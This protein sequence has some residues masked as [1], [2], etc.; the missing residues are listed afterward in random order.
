[1]S[2]KN[3]NKIETNKYELEVTVEADKFKAAVD[4]AFKKNAVK[5]SVPGFR[6]GKAPRAIIE[7]MYGESVFYEDAV[8]MLYPEEYEA[9]VKEAKIEPVDRADVEIESVD[10][11]GFTFKAKV[12]VKPEVE[13]EEYKKLNAA[14]TV[15]KATAEDVDNEI[16]RIQ[17]RNAR[18]ITV[19]DRAAE[20]GDITV[21]DFDGYIDGKAFDGGKAE[22]YNLELGS[23]HFIP[24]FEDQIVGHNPGDSFDVNVKFPDDYQEKG[25]AGKETVFKVKLHEIKKK[26]LTPIDDEF[27]KDVSEFDTLDAMKADIEKHIQEAKDKQAEDDVENQLMSKL[28]EGMKAEIPEVMIEHAIDNQIGDFERRLQMQGISLDQYLAYAGLDMDKFRATFHDQAE[29]QVKVR[30]AL[31]KVVALENIEASDEEV[32]KEYKKIADNYG[33]DVE[34]VKNAFGR[35]D[36][37]KDIQVEKAFSFVKENAEIKEAAEKKE[38]EAEPKKKRKTSK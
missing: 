16:K 25:L 6:K 17:E 38:E 22:K 34:K 9:A 12:T 35:K 27:A 3:L 7:K 36:I 29:R 8:N 32:E 33:V 20:M 5:I 26:E 15:S 21:I 23:G 10:K 31:E 11:D 24:G 13:L 19:E 18:T 2:L 28:T 37:E 30:L 14:K 1:M 4:K